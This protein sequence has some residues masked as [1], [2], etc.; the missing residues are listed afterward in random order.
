[1]SLT[2]STGESLESSGRPRRAPAR[3]PLDGARSRVRAVGH[4]RIRASGHGLSALGAAAAPQHLTLPRRLDWRGLREPPRV[5]TLRR[6]STRMGNQVVK[7][8]SKSRKRRREENQL[9]RSALGGSEVADSDGVGG[10]AASG[11]RLH[12]GIGRGHRSRGSR[13]PR[14]DH[15]ARGNP[16]SRDSARVVSRLPS[17]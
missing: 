5:P 2:R 3:T 6:C 10:L 4:A 13:R 7:S 8:A 17:S 16:V 15:T 12:G 9:A 11:D 14:G 1:M